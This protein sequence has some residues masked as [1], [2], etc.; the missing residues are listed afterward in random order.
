VDWGIKIGGNNER[1]KGE[2]FNKRPILL[3]LRPEVPTNMTS[4]I[5]PRIAA[6]ESMP[7]GHG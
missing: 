5:H 2:F 7:S 3:H 4:R 6:N 1:N